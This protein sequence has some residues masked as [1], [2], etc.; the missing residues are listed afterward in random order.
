VAPEYLLGEPG[1]YQSDLFSLGVIIYEMITGKLPFKEM[2]TNDV[3]LNNFAEM[4]YTPALHHRKDLP[5]WVEGCLRKAVQPNPRFRYEAFS[6]LQ[7]DLTHPN[8]SLE[9]KVQHQPML[10]RNPLLVWK[11]IAAILLGLNLAQ[12]F[13]QH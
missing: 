6:E 10:E 3:T 8:Q 5:L 2:S 13:L 7:A 4:D 12:F 9:A 1:N 11:A